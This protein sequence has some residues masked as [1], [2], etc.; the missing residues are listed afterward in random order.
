MQLALA[1]I[2]YGF[3]LSV[4]LAGRPSAC[5]T[6]RGLTAFLL[7]VLLLTAIDYV[8]VVIL[9]PSPR[10][11]DTIKATYLVHVAPCVALLFGLLA[12]RVERRHRRVFAWALILLCLV[13][14]HNLPVMITHFP[15]TG[16]GG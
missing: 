7:V 2:S 3:L 14:L 5:C 12:A 16:L 13:D 8:Y 10:R 11:G 4:G 15:L 6:T 9:Y 1:G